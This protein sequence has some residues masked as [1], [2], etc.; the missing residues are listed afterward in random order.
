MASNQ[1]QYRL[2][3][4]KAL[5]EIINISATMLTFSGFQL[6]RVNYKDFEKIRNDLESISK[7]ANTI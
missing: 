5:I 6:D 7:S 3:R 4:I 2:K 1:K